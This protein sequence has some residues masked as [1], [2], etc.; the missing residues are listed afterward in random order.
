MARLS[1]TDIPR[2]VLWTGTASDAMFIVAPTE[3][4][5]QV[6][7]HRQG[8][9]LTI[10]DQGAQ[11]MPKPTTTVTDPVFVIPCSRCT[12]SILETPVVAGGPDVTYLT[13]HGWDVSKGW[14]RVACPKHGKP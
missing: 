12:D 14:E 4:P 2:G 5:R 9:L 7:M 8:E 1:Q 10:L 3:V 13:G 11:Q 6:T